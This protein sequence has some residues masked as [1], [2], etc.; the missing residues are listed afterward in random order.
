MCI[1]QVRRTPRTYSLVGPR[2]GCEQALCSGP[3]LPPAR[4]LPMVGTR[5][6][7]CPGPVSQG[8]PLSDSPA[9]VRPCR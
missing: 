9:R 6:R 2:V 7:G 8:R 4:L 3:T 1:T 5:S